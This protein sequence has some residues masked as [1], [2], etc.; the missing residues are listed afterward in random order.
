MAEDLR[1]RTLGEI[2]YGPLTHDELGRVCIAAFPGIEEELI[3][4]V[5]ED[6]LATAGIKPIAPGTIFTAEAAVD[7]QESDQLQPSSFDVLL[8]KD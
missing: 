3:V 1:A 5:S 2:I 7:A 8:K 6:D 4:F